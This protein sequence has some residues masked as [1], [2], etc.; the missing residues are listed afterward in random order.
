MKDYDAVNVGDLIRMVDPVWDW[1]KKDDLGIIVNK[2]E[3]HDIDK[4]G[5]LVRRRFTYKVKFA[6]HI[7]LRTVNRRE[8]EVVSKTSAT[9][10]GS[11]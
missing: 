5:S 11:C 6:R 9:S 8:F 4:N 3:W 1:I 10:G 7:Q 2:K